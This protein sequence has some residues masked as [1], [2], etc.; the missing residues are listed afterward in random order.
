MKAIGKM[1]SFMAM[2]LSTTKNSRDLKALFS[3]RIGVSSNNIGSNMKESSTWTIRRAKA[4]CTYQMDKSSKAVSK[5]IW[6]M[7]KESSA[8]RT[9]AE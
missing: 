9:A 8:D 6:W 2:A 1:I 7:A 4:S 5:G 3:T